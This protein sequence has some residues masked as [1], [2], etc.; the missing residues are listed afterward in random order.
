[1]KIIWGAWL[2]QIV[3][4]RNSW[5]GRKEENRAIVHAVSATFKGAA[6]SMKWSF[7][8]L[9]HDNLV[10]FHE[11][12]P[13][14][15]RGPLSFHHQEFFNFYTSP[16]SASSSSSKLLFNCFTSSWLQEVLLQRS[17]LKL[18]LSLLT[19]LYRFG[20][21]AWPCN[22]GSLMHPIKVTDFPFV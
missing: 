15:C 3:P 7:S 2:S 6:F 12:K 20:V 17:R 19:H 13:Q 16:Y 1:M 5:L 8:S 10:G 4:S 22:L 21:G 9:H 14:K 11:A 18:W